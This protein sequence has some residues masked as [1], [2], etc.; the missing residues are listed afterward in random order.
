MSDH[1]YKIVEP[2][3]KGKPVRKNIDVMRD[4]EI[5]YVAQISRW[6]IPAFLRDA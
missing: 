4:E 6:W 2:Q 3:F 5:K 1:L